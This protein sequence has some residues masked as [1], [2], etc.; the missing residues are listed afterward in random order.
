VIRTLDEFRRD[1]NVNQDRYR[2]FEL[3]RRSIDDVEII[4]FDELLARARFI[5]QHDETADSTEP[6]ETSA[7]T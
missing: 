7:P 4:T 6:G 5:A 2:S 1:N 3:Y